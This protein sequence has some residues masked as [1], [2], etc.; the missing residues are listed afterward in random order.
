MNGINTKGDGLT[1]N[2][3]LGRQ[4]LNSGGSDAQTFTHQQQQANNVGALAI[5]Q[6]CDGTGWTHHATK[7]LTRCQ[8]LGFPHGK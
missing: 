6:A 7:G 1:I 4:T 5:C 2:G 3:D 8:G